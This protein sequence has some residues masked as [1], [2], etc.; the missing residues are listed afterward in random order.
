M[1]RSSERSSYSHDQFAIRNSE[2]HPRYT[3]SIASLQEALESSKHLGD[4]CG[5]PLWNDADQTVV[6]Q[7]SGI[8]KSKQVA[9]LHEQLLAR[10]AASQQTA[11]LGHA[12]ANASNAVA[13][14]GPTPGIFIKRL[15]TASLRERA[16]ISAS[17][18]RI[19][20]T[21]PLPAGAGRFV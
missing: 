13:I 9:I 6:E 12:E 7:I 11:E 16:L 17:S 19:F 3:L 4:G 2:D 5:P 10:A 20:S 1:D 21:K 18:T 15:T 8:A 14:T